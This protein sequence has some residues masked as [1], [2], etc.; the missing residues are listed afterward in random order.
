MALSETC[1]RTLID[2]YGVSAGKIHV[3]PN[4]Y[5]S[6]T[7]NRPTR[8][9]ARKRLGISE[10]EEIVVYAGRTVRHKGIEP[11]LMAIARL[12]R[13]HPH[14]R[15]VMCGSLSGFAN[16]GRLIE[17]VVASLILT[18]FIPPDRL[19]YWYAAADVGVMPSYSEPFGYSGIEMADAGLPVVVADGYSLTDIYEDGVNGFVATIGRDV[20]RT[21]PFA[22]SLTTKID[23]ALNCPTEKRKKIVIESRRRIRD[24]YSADRMAASYFYMLQEMTVK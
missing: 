3:I 22:R 24:L 5:I 23:E 21:A 14:L 17:S 13:M 20:T 16:Y 18:G 2:I 9:Q 12:R 19:R 6:P 4:G 11:L 7:G 8:S 10:D 15:C 1:R